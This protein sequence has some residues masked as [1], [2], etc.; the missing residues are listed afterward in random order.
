MAQDQSGCRGSEER[1]RPCSRAPAARDQE[2]EDGSP[3]LINAFGERSIVL[4][5]ARS[6]RGDFADA[7]IQS[8]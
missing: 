7:F 6:H 2:E 8:D 4:K 5:E 1:R 3:P